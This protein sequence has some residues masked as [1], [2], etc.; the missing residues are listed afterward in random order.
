MLAHVIK[1]SWV[2]VNLEGDSVVSELWQCYF[3]CLLLNPG[4]IMHEHFELPDIEALELPLYHRSHGRAATFSLRVKPCRIALA[5]F[6]T[7]TTSRTS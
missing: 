4:K 7:S 1:H 3:I 2:I 5:I 6:L